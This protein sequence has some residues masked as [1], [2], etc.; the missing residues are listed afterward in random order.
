MNGKLDADEL[1]RE[2]TFEIDGIGG[3]RNWAGG[4]YGEK[5]SRK[6]RNMIG[7]R[8][9]TEQGK[10]STYSSSSKLTSML[11]GQSMSEADNFKV[12]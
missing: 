10:I 8:L 11:R 5:R 2:P 12:S 7:N 6:K 3:S 1:D 4:E 9:N